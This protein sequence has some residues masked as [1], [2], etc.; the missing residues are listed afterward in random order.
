[1][2]LLS[3]PPLVLSLSLRPGASAAPP[4][5]QVWAWGDA[6]DGQLGFG[7]DAQY[8][9]ENPDWNGAIPFPCPTVLNSRKEAVVAVA[10]GAPLLPSSR[11]RPLRRPRGILEIYNMARH[12]SA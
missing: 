5:A 8:R 9:A 4:A 12:P 3:R 11:A 6:R 7:S 2:R 1:M 10:A